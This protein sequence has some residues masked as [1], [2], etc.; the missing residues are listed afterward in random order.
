MGTSF[1]NVALGLGA[2]LTTAALVIFTKGKAKKLAKTLEQGN[3]I[4]KR[5]TIKLTQTANQG[6]TALNGLSKG[7]KGLRNTALFG[8]AGLGG[9]AIMTSCK[10]DFEHY[11]KLDHETNWEGK[12][13]DIPTR[14]DTITKTDIV[15][16]DST[17]RDT[18]HLP[19]EIVR[20]TIYQ[21]DTTYLPGETVRDTIFQDRV[22]HD[23]T[24]IE[25]PIYIEVP[26]ETVYVNPQYEGEPEPVLDDITD[27]LA[28]GT[29]K[30]G[31]TVLMQGNKMFEQHSLDA[32]IDDG[33]CSQNTQA[34]ALHVVDYEDD[35]NPTT[36]VKKMNI[37]KA[38]VNGK[39]GITCTIIPPMAGAKK[40]TYKEMDGL[41]WDT[42]NAKTIVMVPDK[43]NNRVLKYVK[44]ADG[45]TT[46]TGYLY[47]DANGKIKE[48]NYLENGQNWQQEIKDFNITHAKKYLSD[49]F[50]N[51]Y[52]KQ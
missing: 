35:H 49:I 23:T 10:S 8:I 45:T 17:V 1:K 31:V 24:Y 12:Y 21:N 3:K 50:P 30:D 38:S 34:Y 28:P 37:E 48:F 41:A 29:N 47:K 6:K 43:T 5:P 25:K 52:P 46:A 7:E 33:N 32:R 9:A 11:N 15:Y 4:L 44:N 27:I 16:R 18:I 20:D 14:W 13:V 26:G 2:G 40:R 19:G 51:L 36:Y 22:V 39:D 42:Q